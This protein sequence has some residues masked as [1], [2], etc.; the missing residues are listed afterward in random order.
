MYVAIWHGFILVRILFLVFCFEV[1]ILW[2]VDYLLQL[3]FCLFWEGS[4]EYSDAIRLPYI[5]GGT[6]RYRKSSVHVWVNSMKRLY[7][8]RH[9]IS[10]NVAPW[11]A[12]TQTS[13]WTSETSLISH[14]WGPDPPPPPKKKKK[15]KKKK[16]NNN[17]PTVLPTTSDSDVMFCLQRYQ[18]LII[19]RSLG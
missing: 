3:L 10:N 18:G 1:L 15:K 9:V 19:D 5:L 7:E 14:S 13:P 8:P 6:W 12:Q 17:T 16:N 11:Q 4:C 2:K